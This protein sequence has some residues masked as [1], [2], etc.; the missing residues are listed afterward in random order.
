M[1]AS[2]PLGRNNRQ[3][4]LLTC[5]M[6]G[7][8]LALLL[9]LL[10]LLGATAFAYQSEDPTALLVPLAYVIEMLTAFFAGLLAARRR[11]RQGLLCGL[12]AGG[13]MLVLFSLGHL[14]LVGDSETAFLPLLLSDLLLLAVSLLGGVLGAAMPAGGV[15]RVRRVK[16]Y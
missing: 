16:R 8:F 5:V 9:M 3:G 15:R 11:K 2:L 6:R 1:D 4:R 14:T 12:L 13:A 7:V 10:L